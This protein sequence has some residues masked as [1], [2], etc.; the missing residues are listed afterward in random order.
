MARIL[1]IEDFEG[2]NVMGTVE[3]LFCG[4]VP[5]DDDSD[6]KQLISS[7]LKRFNITHINNFVSAIHY[8]WNFDINKDFDFIIIDV[9]LDIQARGVKITEE[10]QKHRDVYIERCRDDGSTDPESDLKMTA[11]FYIYMLLLE[12][13]NFIR[14]NIRFYSEHAGSMKI[15][16]ERIKNRILSPKDLIIQKSDSANA[17]KMVVEIINNPYFRLR[18]AVI[19][20]CRTL[21]D[22]K[23]ISPRVDLGLE[24]HEIE[25]HLRLISDALPSIDHKHTDQTKTEKIYHILLILILL[26]WDSPK[27][28]SQDRPYV[29]TLAKLRNAVMHYSVPNSKV[30]ITGPDLAY[31]FLLNA[32]LL[33]ERDTEYNFSDLVNLIGEP[34]SMESDELKERYWR[35]KDEIKCLINY[36]KKEKPDIWQGLLPKLLEKYNKYPDQME[37]I[38]AVIG[39]LYEKESVESLPNLIETLYLIFWEDVVERPK[40]KTPFRSKLQTRLASSGGLCPKR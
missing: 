15:F 9:N 28:N 14:N 1:W 19:K 27:P 32:Y 11:G 16:M 30:R 31:I 22:G 5:H 24:R 37:Q 8:L 35:S 36:Y 25:E 20:H 12:H 4:I 26:P 17:N 33:L 7:Y 23:K 34:F 40:N 13:N 21:I 29:N 39:N 6:D 18:S 2:G 10:L 38:V 3:D